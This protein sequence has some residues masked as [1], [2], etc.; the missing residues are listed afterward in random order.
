[1]KLYN[2]QLPQGFQI[3]GAEKAGQKT[4]AVSH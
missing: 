2:L 3:M 1:M 4:G